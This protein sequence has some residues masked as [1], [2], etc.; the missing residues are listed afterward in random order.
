MA[1]QHNPN[2]TLIWR[3][4]SASADGGNCVEVA[5]LGMSVLVRDSDS[6]AGTMLE[7]RQAQWRGFMGRIKTGNVVSG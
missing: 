6:Q 1:T 2:S 5:K 4:S 3:K 7:F